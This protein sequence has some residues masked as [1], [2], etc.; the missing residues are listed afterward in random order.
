MVLPTIT[1]NLSG[2]GR[3]IYYRQLQEQVTFSLLLDKKEMIVITW[4]QE[5]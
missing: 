4:K 5:T 3:A 2:L 1:C